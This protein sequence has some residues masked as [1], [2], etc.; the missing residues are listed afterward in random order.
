MTNA[1]TDL[2]T[3]L[4]AKQ[5]PSTELEIEERRRRERK[6]ERERDRTDMEAAI[7]EE[8][9]A[10][11]NV[12]EEPFKDVIQ[13]QTDE[14]LPSVPRPPVDLF[15]AVFASSDDEVD[16]DVSVDEEPP[17]PSPPKLSAVI[18]T[19]PLPLVGL[20][21]TLA[22]VIGPEAL[23]PLPTDDDS[24]TLEQIGCVRACAHC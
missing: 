11:L 16:S 9:K 13:P 5:L 22:R 3:A 23:M 17:P 6:A 19:A 21:A 24:V 4:G 1:S 15:K 18:D 10:H 7:K 12:K 8:S 20:R 14:P 2:Q